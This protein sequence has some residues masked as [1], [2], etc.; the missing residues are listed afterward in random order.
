MKTGV[1]PLLPPPPPPTKRASEKG[2]RKGWRNGLTYLGT[3]KDEHAGAECWDGCARLFWAPTV[4]LA[5]LQ[6][7]GF[8][9]NSKTAPSS[10]SSK[11]ALPTVHALPVILAA[12]VLKR[13]L[14]QAGSQALSSH[15][16]VNTWPPVCHMAA[17]GSRPGSPP[18]PVPQPLLP[19][20]ATCPS[21][22]SWERTGPNCRVG[23]CQ[24]RTRLARSGF[25]KQEGERRQV[26][27]LSRALTQTPS[28][29]SHAAPSPPLAPSPRV[30]SLEPCKLASLKFILT[31]IWPACK[32]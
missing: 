16:P 5:S 21:C 27:L 20:W 24:Q 31:G 19:A 12:L 8:T 14:P 22:L 2:K 9:P 25:Q 32:A 7:N 28:R 18:A 6:T 3:A 29:V 13:P 26:S 11:Y 10:S 17:L 30:A 23:G 1:A 15:P 4:T